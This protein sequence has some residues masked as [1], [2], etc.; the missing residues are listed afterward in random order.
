VWCP[1]FY[2]P[3]KERRSV[4]LGGDPSISEQA[5]YTW[6]RQNCIDKGPSGD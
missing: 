4:Q 2:D 1:G 3:L 5:L 6:R